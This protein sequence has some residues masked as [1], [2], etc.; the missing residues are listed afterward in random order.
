M[1]WCHD[2]VKID[3]ES[4]AIGSAQ[5][6]TNRLKTLYIILM[7]VINLYVVISTAAN[8]NF[9]T[10]GRKFWKDSS[11]F[12]GKYNFL[13]SLL[14]FIHFSQSHGFQQAPYPQQRR[15]QVYNHI[16]SHT[17]GI[18]KMKQHSEIPERSVG[19]PF[20]HIV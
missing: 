5:I 12:V 20:R 14:V 1:R 7:V 2:S 16:Q 10:E 13:R 17:K 19:L 3:I 15:T 8:L 4:S 18:K 11:L 6:S 9:Q